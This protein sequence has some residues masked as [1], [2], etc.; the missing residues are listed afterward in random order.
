VRVTS[1]YNDHFN[2]FETP[3]I[4]ATKSGTVEK[5]ELKKP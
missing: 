5:L 3:E 4:D 1:V 2:S